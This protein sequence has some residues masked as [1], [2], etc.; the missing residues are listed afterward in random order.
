MIFSRPALVLA[1]AAFSLSPLEEKTLDSSLLMPWKRGMIEGCKGPPFP[2]IASYEK[3]NKKLLF[4]A[5]FH[6]VGSEHPSH[7]KV[8][9]AVEILHPE[10]VIVE[11]IPFSCGMNCP[12]FLAV[13]LKNAKT[14]FAHAGENLYSIFQAHK[15]C[16][17]FIGGEPDDAEILQDCLQKGYS[18]EDLIGFYLLD[19]FRNSI[20]SVKPCFLTP[21]TP[22]FSAM[23]IHMA[24]KLGG[25]SAQKSLVSPTKANF[26]R[27]LIINWLI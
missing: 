13:A 18:R 26:E 15:N 20:R 27:S 5:S 21:S 7:Q 24:K 6:G 4:V 9:E 8:R 23:C 19:F 2:F 10:I 17:S 25:E 14:D 16:F 3:D 1:L 22:N 11:G 12:G